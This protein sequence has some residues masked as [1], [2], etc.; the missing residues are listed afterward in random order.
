MYLILSWKACN[1]C[2]QAHNYKNTIMKHPE[3][4]LTDLAYSVNSKQIEIQSIM[5]WNMYGVAQAHHANDNWQLSFDP[6]RFGW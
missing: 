1:R 3:K 6:T 2:D 4:Q 5:F